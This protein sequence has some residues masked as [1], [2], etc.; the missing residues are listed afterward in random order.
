MGHSKAGQSLTRRMILKRTGRS[1]IAAGLG[2]LEE[3]T[4]HD[5]A[6]GMTANV[7]PTR[8]AAAVS[9]EPRHGLHRAIFESVA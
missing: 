6:H 3:L 9:E 7:F 1:I 4:S 5:R 8:I 2:N